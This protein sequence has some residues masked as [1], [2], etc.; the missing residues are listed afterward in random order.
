M[1]KVLIVG[2]TGQLGGRVFEKLAETL[3]YTLR[4]LI[5]KDSQ[6]DHLLAQGPEV[7]FGDLADREKVDLAVQSCDIVI[8]TASAAIPR[9]EEDTFELVDTRGHQLLI[10][11]AKKYG[12]EHFIYVSANFGLWYRQVVPL[13]KAKFLTES[14]L[15]ASGVPY[16]IY[17]PEPFMDV[18][19]ALMGTT[20]P[21]RG[22]R[23]A[24]VRRP[25]PFLQR[26][27]EGIKNNLQEGKLG[28]AGRPKIYHS[29]IAID[30][31]ADFILGAVESPGLR[32]K[33]FLLGGPQALSGYEIK[34]LFEKLLGKSLTFKKSPAWMM[35]SMGWVYSWFNPIVANIFLMNYAMA[36]HSTR[37]DSNALANRLGI[38]L[39]SAE[40]FLRSKLGAARAAPAGA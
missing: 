18:H 35:L 34:A 20:I 28:I 21:L 39:I 13:A 23:S 40:E 12:I 37:V 8:T 11:A 36:R 19:F 32:N 7:V 25:F 4:I 3:Q 1:K 29:Y 10:D 24:T 27:F 2:A 9:K 33:S 5:R 30:N 38:R 6:H 17:A 16:T 14:Y 15:K 31:V 26:F 22:E